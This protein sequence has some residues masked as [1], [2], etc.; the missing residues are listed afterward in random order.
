[1]G[2]PTDCHLDLRC[3]FPCTLMASPQQHMSSWREAPGLYTTMWDHCVLPVQGHGHPHHHPGS[4]APP[5]WPRVAHY[6]EVPCA[7]LPTH[8]TLELSVGP[9]STC[10]SLSPDAHGYHAEVFV[11]GSPE[12]WDFPKVPHLHPEQLNHFCVNIMSKTPFN[13]KG[14]PGCNEKKSECSF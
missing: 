7:E 4:P 2:S 6:W 3:C 5:Q 8:Q 1:M 9:I 11:R 13:Q 14:H 12:S 10:T